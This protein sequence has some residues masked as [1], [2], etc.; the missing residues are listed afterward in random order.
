MI[1]QL[2]IAS[3]ILCFVSTSLTLAGTWSDGFERPDLGEWKVR[4]R[5]GNE[6]V[7]EIKNGL[8]LGY[9]NG[10]SGAWIGDDKW[11]NYSVEADVVL[12]E[13][14]TPGPDTPDS[15][16]AVMAMYWKEV[17]FQGYLFEI[18]PFLWD[19]IGRG[20]GLL[21]GVFDGF[22]PPITS[23]YKALEV[24]FG[25]EYSLRMA[26]ENGFIKCY[27]DGELVL[28]IAMDNRFTSGPAGFRIIN[29]RVCF[30]NFIVTGNNI[31]DGGPGLGKV[32]TVESIGK[33]A[34]KWAE[35]KSK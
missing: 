35:I 19:G 13:E 27:L 11:E 29:A 23:K 8:L 18:G 1:R 10:C 2:T 3:L 31:P 33:L 5:V 9:Q 24:E 12:L 32:T 25:R 4:R 21:V 15:H 7:W 6:P 34:I 30:D 16:A 26:E 14:L 28:E 22:R 20:P 17:P